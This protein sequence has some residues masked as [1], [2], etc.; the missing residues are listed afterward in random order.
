MSEQNVSGEQV[1]NLVEKAQ[2]KGVFNITDFAKGRAYPQ[3]TVIAYT[4][5]DSAYE[6]K[7][8]NEEIADASLDESDK[9][10]KLEEKVQEL[11]K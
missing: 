3:D 1:L 11:S 2:A 5:V 7:K 8:I 6:L 4:D 10:S 9:I